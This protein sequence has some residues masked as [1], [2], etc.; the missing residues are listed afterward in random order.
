MNIAF[1]TLFLNTFARKIFKELKY[2]S[3]FIHFKYGY[4]TYMFY[5][6]III[7]SMAGIPPFAGFFGKYFLFIEAFNANL[8]SLIILGLF[9]SLISTYYYI[10]II[11]I[12]F[13]ETSEALELNEFGEQSS[14]TV[15]GFLINSLITE[16]VNKI[17]RLT[18]T[19]GIDMFINLSVLPVGI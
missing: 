9:T 10:R 5:F 18:Y 16:C 15:N 11:K 19:R 7:F 12:S 13:F 2:F 14:K 17:R 1:F 6:T 3:E 4:P 8:V